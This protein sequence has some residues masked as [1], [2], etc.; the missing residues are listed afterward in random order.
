MVH[1]ALF[2]LMFEAANTRP[3]FTISLKRS[4]KNLQL[5]TSGQPI[6]PSNG[7]KRTLSRVYEYTALEH[8]RKASYGLRYSLRRRAICHDAIEAGCPSIDAWSA[9]AGLKSST[10][11]FASATISHSIGPAQKLLPALAVPEE[12]QQA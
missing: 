1:A 5:S 9:P 4:T 12:K 6:T 7:A 3:R 10:S 8:L 11:A 2:L